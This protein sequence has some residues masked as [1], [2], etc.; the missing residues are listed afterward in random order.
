MDDD[1]YAEWL[2]FLRSFKH[3]RKLEINHDWVE[4]PVA[5]L[6]TVVDFH[7]ACP[8]LRGVRLHYGDGGERMVEWTWNGD[9]GAWGNSGMCEVGST[10]SFWEESVDELGI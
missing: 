10:K 8:S 7:K 1:E 5:P 9:I 6:V 2:S 4:A 3:L